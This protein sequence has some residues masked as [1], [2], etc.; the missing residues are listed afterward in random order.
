[1]VFLRPIF[2]GGNRRSEW[3]CVMR[4][5]EMEKKM[6]IEKQIEL[7][8]I[9][10]L[11]MELA[12][13]EWAKEKIKDTS[14]FLS[15]RTLRKQLRDTTDGKQLVEKLG[16]PPLQGVGEI[17]EIIEIAEKGGCLDP[18]QLEKTERALA[19]MRRLKDYLGRGKAYDEQR[20]SVRYRRRTEYGGESVHLLGPYKE[21]AGGAGR[22]RRKQFCNYG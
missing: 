3:F 5:E 6:N 4:E 12:V 9:K 20:L 13:T 16:T 2:G 18:G 19:A 15:E 8:K 1:M 22:N 17:K 10:E 21:C 7:D 11:W 14:F